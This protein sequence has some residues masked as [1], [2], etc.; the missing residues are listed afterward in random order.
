MKVMEGKVKLRRNLI[1]FKHR[2]MI[3]LEDGRVILAK[4]REVRTVFAL[5]RS[6]EIK[7]IKKDRFQIR[8]MTVHENIES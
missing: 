7:L 1:F 8:T 3:L 5:D 2:D 4:D 6:T